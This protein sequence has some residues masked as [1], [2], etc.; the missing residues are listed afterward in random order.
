MHGVFPKRD[1]RL[2]GSVAAPRT[3]CFFRTYT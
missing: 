2:A 3:Y 1:V